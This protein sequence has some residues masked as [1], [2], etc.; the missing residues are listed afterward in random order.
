MTNKYILGI[1]I[2]TT[3]VKVCVLDP[4]SNEVISSHKKDT[5][6]D[7]PSELG[8]EGN[9]QDVPR[10]LSACQMCVSR[11][12]RDQLR[13]IYR[14]GICGQMHGCM[15][16]KQG[17]AWERKVDSERY[18]IKEVSNVY[19]WQDSRC[20]TEFLDQLP[21]PS[22]HLAL[23]S[24]YG[25]ATL[26]WLAKN[27]PE[28][29]D[30]FDRAG[31]IHDFF[32]SI[33]CGLDKPTMSVQN[34]AAWGYFNT[35]KEEWNTEQLE[36]AG[37][38]LRYL[39][40]VVSSGKFAGKLESSWYGIPKDTPVLAS[41]GDLQCSVL[42]SLTAETD[43]VINISTSAQI[44]F[45]LSSDFK[46]PSQPSPTPNPVDYFPYFDGSY[47]AVAASLNGGNALAA[48]VRT[49]QQWVL[50]LG[51]QVP[52]SKIWERTLSLGSS[53]QSD[54]NLEVEPT[55]FGER[56]SPERSACAS[57]INIGNISL[58]KV[59]KALCRGVIKNLHSMMPRSLLVENGVNRIIGG[60]SA[61]VRN[62]ILQREVEEQYQLPLTLDAR[63]NAAYGAALAAKNA[64]IN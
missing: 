17:S 44:C 5:C 40:N 36:E 29:F 59:M 10:I 46:P 60:G 32:V 6:S 28:M 56:H 33:I 43:A 52:Q 23:A 34:A 41:L 64:V 58:G 3:S 9:K 51:F 61:L 4:S 42:P 14:I 49:L 39:P 57:N 45:K 63:G 15:L 62:K 27:K 53:D 7:V 19:T 24:G 25:C 38:P 18:E 16:W 22:S 13:K 30:E 21:T 2:G 31:T 55:L 54:S 48:F 26:I 8:S 20:S 37:L 12:P 50:E 1:D 35:E 47:L 11:L